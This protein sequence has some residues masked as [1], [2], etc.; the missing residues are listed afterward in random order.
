MSEIPKLYW[1]CPLCNHTIYNL[2]KTT[3]LLYIKNAVLNNKIYQSVGSK[4]IG[5]ATNLCWQYIINIKYNKTHDNSTIYCQL[6][7]KTPTRILFL[8]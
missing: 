7:I 5:C 6:K 3:I 4:T 8:L 1:Y 2:G